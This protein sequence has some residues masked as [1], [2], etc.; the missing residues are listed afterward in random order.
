MATY[1][2]S[3]ELFILEVLDRSAFPISF[4]RCARVTGTG[5]YLND[6]KLS[7]N[8]LVRPAIDIAA[9]G[10]IY[11]LKQPKMISFSYF[12]FQSTLVQQC[13]FMVAI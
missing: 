12:P 5:W 7:D 13:Y 9:L 3:R 8:W 6:S 4:F 10:V 11:K 1:S 2:L